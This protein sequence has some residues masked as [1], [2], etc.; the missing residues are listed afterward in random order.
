MIPDRT[1]EPMSSAEA[2]GWIESSTG[3]HMCASLTAYR[4]GLCPSSDP[5]NTPYFPVVVLTIRFFTSSRSAR[6]VFSRY[7]FVVSSVLPSQL[8]FLYFFFYDPML[9][10]FSM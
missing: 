1:H 2:L 3:V 10:L 9:Q 8:Q 5:Q 4:T 7:P 6:L